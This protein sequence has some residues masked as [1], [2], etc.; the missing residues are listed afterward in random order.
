M[1]WAISINFF[2]DPTPFLENAPLLTST[3]TEIHRIANVPVSQLAPREDPSK[4]PIGLFCY[5]GV[6]M[7]ENGPTPPCHNS[8]KTMVELAGVEPA[9]S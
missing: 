5:H 3:G 4:Q 2:N 1:W 7:E 6:T 8:L 9:T